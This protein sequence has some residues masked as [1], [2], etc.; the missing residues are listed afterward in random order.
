MDTPGVYSTGYMPE[1]RYVM[2]KAL[3]RSLLAHETVHH[4]NGDK[5]D[6]R[7]ENLQLR[8]GKH[9]KGV[10]LQCRSCGSHDVEATEL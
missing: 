6:N 9:G 5:E 1:H 8:N 10:K 4:I 7:L 2:Q 3:G